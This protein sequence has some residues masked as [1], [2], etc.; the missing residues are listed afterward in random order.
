M[1]NY[2]AKMHKLK[3]FFTLPNF[4][5]NGERIIRNRINGELSVVHKFMQKFCHI[6]IKF[7]F[8]ILK[9]LIF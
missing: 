5:I 8:Y 1:E 6:S 2:L 3:I 9:Q 7:H 4:C